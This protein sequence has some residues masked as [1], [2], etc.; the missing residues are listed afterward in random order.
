MSRVTGEIDVVAAVIEAEGRFLLAQRPVGKVYAGYW[1]FP[2]G[3][4]E[5]GESDAQ[6][7]SRE[8]N[9][10]LGIHVRSATPW[11]VRR[12]VY[13]HAHVRLRFFRV[14][15]WDG[16][17][18]AL[19]HQAIAWHRHRDFATLPLQIPAT[20]TPMLPAN[21]PILTALGLPP[22]YAITQ[23]ER[24]GAAAELARLERGLAAGIGLIQVRDKTLPS[25]QRRA[26]AGQVV[27]RAHA[28][29]ARVLINDDLE[30]MAEVN[31]DGLHC[32]AA[33]LRQWLAEGASTAFA[34]RHAGHKL[35]AASC[36]NADELAQAAAAGCDFACLGAVLPTPTH[37]EQPGM[38]WPSF[39]RLVEPGSLPVYALG[40]MDAAQNA[41]AAAAG[42]HGIALMR[43][44]G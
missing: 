20:A 25:A 16:E 13:P 8:L 34:Q 18:Q 5:A 22:I 30:L 14:T 36:H 40:G 23:A 26:F 17:P 12:F 35:L 44:W 2:G 37:P 38:G 15:A 31:A 29:G 3:K 43:G 7:L 1:E 33:G 28:A 21:G 27:A 24:V 10:E 6:A 39:A 11:L 41:A 19:E 9:E 4:V 32:S 42:A